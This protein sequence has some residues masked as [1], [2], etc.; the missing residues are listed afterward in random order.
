MAKSKRTVMERL[1]RAFAEKPTRTLAEK[2][3]KR[4]LAAKPQTTKIDKTVALNFGANVAAV[5][6]HNVQTRVPAGQQPPPAPVRNPPRAIQMGSGNLA[7]IADYN[8]ATK[9]TPVAAK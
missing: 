6:A 4:T 9:R 5:V 1:R 3:G 8:A 2:P 7:A